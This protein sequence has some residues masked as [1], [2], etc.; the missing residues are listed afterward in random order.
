MNGCSGV[1]TALGADLFRVAFH[2]KPGAR[3]TSIVAVSE[4]EVEVRLAAPPVE[5][6]ANE[7]LLSYVQ[8]ILP[9]ASNVRIAMGNRGR[10][11]LVEL[12]CPGAGAPDILRAFQKL[13]P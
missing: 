1:V 9:S 2:C 3:S 13:V 5:G 8:E 11:K 7:E 12:Q 6:K 10:A 4:D